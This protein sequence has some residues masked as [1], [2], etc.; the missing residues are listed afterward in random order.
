MYA[1]KVKDLRHTYPAGRKKDAVEVLKGINLEIKK[2]EIFGFLGPNGSG[3]TT[4][5]KILSTLFAPT[6]GSAEIFGID[7]SAEQFE[8]RKKIGVVFQHPS[9]DKKLTAKENLRHHGHLFGLSGEELETRIDELLNRFGMAEKSNEL[10]ETFSGGQQRRVELAKGLLHKPEML[11]LD[12]PSTGIDPGARRLLWDALKKLKEEDGV[13]IL[14]TTHLLSE[15]EQCERIAMLYNGEIVAEGTPE[16]LKGEV[17]GD[18]LTVSTNSPDEFARQYEAKFNN[19]PMMVNGK[20][21]IEMEDGHKF[22]AELVDA[23]SELVTSVT[24]GKPTLEDFFID[25]T[26]DSFEVNGGEK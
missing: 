22:V 17:G 6:K 2:G 1:V 10:V 21:R 9:L 13:T 23:F 14:V 8:A 16:S 20:V 26:G 4:L 11:I 3:K 12:E 25:K 15:A 7:I 19:K 18:V 24:Y 5:F